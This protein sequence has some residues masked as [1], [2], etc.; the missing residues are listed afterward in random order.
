MILFILTTCRYLIGNIVGST[1]CLCLILE[2]SA[3]ILYWII[4]CLGYIWG[5]LTDAMPAHIRRVYTLI[6]L[7]YVLINLLVIQLGLFLKRIPINDFPF[8]IGFVH[9]TMSNLLTTFMR[10][11]ILF[12]FRNIVNA[13]RSPEAMVVIKSPV[14]SV[15]VNK[16]VSCTLYEC[17]KLVCSVGIVC[18]LPCSCST[19]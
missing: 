14:I 6:G 12:L 1:V 2:D 19:T 5:S 9:F 7:S 8:D 13:I 16:V 4:A 11:T 3:D 10:N 18:Q 15:K 17:I